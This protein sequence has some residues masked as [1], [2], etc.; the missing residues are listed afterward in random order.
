MYEKCLSTFICCGYAYWLTPTL[1]HLG[2]LPRLWQLGV[3]VAKMKWQHEDIIEAI[4]HCWLLLTSMFDVWKVFE[5]L[6]MLLIGM[7]VHPYTVTMA[8]LVQ[9][10]NL[11]TLWL[12]W[13]DGWWHCW[14]CRPPLTASFIHIGCMKSVWATSLLLI[15]ILVHPPHTVTLAKLAL[16]LGNLGSVWLW[17]DGMMTLLR[18]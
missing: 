3:S 15:G 11:G 17:N 10:G 18:L 8:M 9:L 13:N 2:R 1:L 6:H 16:L 5:H 4:D 7:W 14:G 12:H